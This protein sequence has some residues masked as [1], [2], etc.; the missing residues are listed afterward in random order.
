MKKKKNEQPVKKLY[1][2]KGEDVDRF[3]PLENDDSQIG[4]I[5]IKHGGRIVQ[6]DDNVEGRGK[7]ASHV[8]RILGD[9]ATAR[10]MAAARRAETTEIQE[11]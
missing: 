11:S 9:K 3:E 2:I 8:R 1:L 7:L 6:F 5:R 4:C 10:M